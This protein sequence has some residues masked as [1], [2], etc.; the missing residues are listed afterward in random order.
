MKT[1]TLKTL[2]LLALV[3]TPARARGA[4]VGADDWRAQPYDHDGLGIVAKSIEFKKGKLWLKLQFLNQ[5]ENPMTINPDAIQA[6]L[7]TGVAVA[8]AKGVFDKSSSAHQAK[9]LQPGVG[10]EIAIEYEI[11]DGAKTVAL[12]LNFGV[13]VNGKIKKFPEWV[14][15]STVTWSAASKYVHNNLTVTIV[16]SSLTKNGVE[17]KMKVDNQNDGPIYIEKKLFK[18][19]LPNGSTIDREKTLMKNWLTILGHT[20]D[21]FNIEFKCGDPAG[22]I[23]VMDGINMGVLGLPELPLKRQ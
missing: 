6:K 4:R 1:L 12:Q 18:V 23:L 21:D 17:L 11:G 20:E 10:E 7:P 2:L 13:T 9:S 19:K 5:T 3:A 14:T 16:S 15:T 22:M 8:R